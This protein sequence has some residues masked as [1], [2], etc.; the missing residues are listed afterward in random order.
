MVQGFYAKTLPC[1]RPGVYVRPARDFPQTAT[2][3]A[4]TRSRPGIYVRPS[5]ESTASQLLATL[6]AVCG[7]LVTF[8]SHAL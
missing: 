8:V 3:P 1:S 4:L 5:R 7:L 2:G 6:G